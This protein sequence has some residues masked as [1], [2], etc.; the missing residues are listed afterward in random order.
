MDERF[1]SFLGTAQ[2]LEATTNSGR[3]VAKLR[4]AVKNRELY[5][6]HQ[7]LRTIYFRF[8]NTKPK[9][10][11]LEGLLYH[12]TNYLLDAGEEVS[13]LDIAALYL[14]TAAKFLKSLHDEGGED[15]KLYL[16]EPSLKLHTE[17]RSPDLDIS[18]KIANIS[19]KLPD[20]ELS[21][22]KFIADTMKILAHKILNKCLL[23]EVL[24]HQF[25]EN[26]DFV[27]S[28]Y[29]YL[30]CAS[31]ENAESV[32]NFLIEYQS[33]S[34][35][36][37]EIDLFITQFIFQFLCLQSPSDPPRLCSQNSKT[38]T[39]PTSPVIGKTRS[40]IKSV[41]DRIFTTYISKHPQ[42]RQTGTPFSSFPLLNFTYF[43]ISML[44]VDCEAT[45]FTVLKDVYKT[46]W[47][48]D[49]NYQGYL[50]RVGTLYFG[51]V[52][53]TKQRQGGLLNNILLSLLDDTED[54]EPSPREPNNNLSP[55]DDLD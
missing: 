23:H 43:I 19:V 7:I 45:A 42:L 24:A 34:A 46:S 6:T 8:I 9:I 20:T 47:C 31:L 38:V 14:E 39:A 21:R 17:W 52:D 13:A 30:H 53:Q 11:A 25:R 4:L 50:S 37:S 32:G 10:P 36:K 49:P 12:G 27:N 35:C 2:F 26:R 28:R 33:G 55:C 51:I 40:N 54:E 18:R 3:L 29:H 44:D 22:Q 16:A 48:R 15:A 41:A 1:T 5:E